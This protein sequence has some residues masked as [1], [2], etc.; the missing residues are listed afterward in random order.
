MLIV[1]PLAAV[2][3]FSIF[4]RMAGQVATSRDWH[5]VT[6]SP[7]FPR[8]LKQPSGKDITIAALPVRIVAANCG[9]ADILQE[10]IDPKRFAAVPVQVEEYAVDP[11]FWKNHAGIPRFEK[12]QAERILGYRPDLVVSSSF[13]DGSTAAAI[14]A[15]RVPILYLKDF[16][17]LDGIRDTIATVGKATGSEVAAAKIIAQFDAQLK[18]VAEA[19]KETKPVTVILYSNFGTGYTAG[20]GVCQNDI[21]TRA[22]GINLAAQHGMKG[23]VPL[24]FEQ[25]LRMD[26]DYIVV[27]GNDGL[28]SPQAKVVLSESSL[29]ELRAVKN[30]HIA[31]VPSRYLIA[32]SQHAVEAVKSVARQLHPEAKL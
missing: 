1:V 32:L 25:L 15:Q 24:T 31:V 18:T 12:F 16:E 17:A 28:D 5:S 13:Q 26:P 30:R 23:H 9:A 6:L 3:F 11:Q 19:L 22:G 4:K 29:K 14:E 10:L 21:I 27:S 7:G 8:S 20:S 2:V